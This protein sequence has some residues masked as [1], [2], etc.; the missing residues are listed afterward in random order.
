MF[1]ATAFPSVDELISMGLYQQQLELFEGTMMVT[2]DEEFLCDIKVCWGH[3]K[4]GITTSMK[5]IDHP[6]FTEVRNFLGD[7]GYVSIKRGHVN[8]DSVTKP[9]YL[10]NKLFNEGDQFVCAVAMKWHLQTRGELNA[11]S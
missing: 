2:I 3:G 9:F 1:G 5:H 10:N 6:S 8:G 11:L 7:G 4:N